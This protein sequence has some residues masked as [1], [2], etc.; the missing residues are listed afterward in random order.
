MFWIDLILLDFSL[1]LSSVLFAEGNIFYLDLVKRCKVQY[2]A[3]LRDEKQ[4]IANF[5]YKSVVSQE[6]RF[7]KKTNGM[8][9]E[10][11]KKDAMNKVRAALRVSINNLK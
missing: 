4:A 10:V 1:I 5:V 3:S 7:L 8:W 6:G 2:V 9:F 11:E